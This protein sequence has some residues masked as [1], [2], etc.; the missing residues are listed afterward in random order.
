VLRSVSS[1]IFIAA[2]AFSA[3]A[4]QSTVA[5][6]TPGGTSQ[7]ATPSPACF[8]VTLHCFTLKPLSGA[9]P[10]RLDLRAPA[11][12]AVVPQSELQGV[13]PDPDEPK[14][15]E[16]LV[17]VEGE[18]GVP[19]NVPVGI[20]SLPWAVRHPSQFWRIFL[21]SPSRLTKED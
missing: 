14:Y 10:S 12:A 5:A 6:S 3:H 19:V 2:L 18:R 20:M 17:K 15:D 21:P 7:V 4:Q 11:I 13:L 8:S 9:E 16:P 1:G